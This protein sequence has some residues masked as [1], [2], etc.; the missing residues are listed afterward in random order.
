MLRRLDDGSSPDDIDHGRWHRLQVEVSTA[1]IGGL[2]LLALV[3]LT[4]ASFRVEGT[5]LRPSCPS[6]RPPREEGRDDRDTE[7]E[8]SGQ[9]SPPES[10]AATRAERPIRGC[11]GSQPR[12][13]ISG[14]RRRY[15]RG[16]PTGPR[17]SNRTA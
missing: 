14:E 10:D 8:S 13:T 3:A 6:I 15:P 16:R 17:G 4:L 9:P 5:I 7:R 11:E 2:S 1:P 12:R